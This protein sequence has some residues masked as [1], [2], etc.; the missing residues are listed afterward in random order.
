MI[1]SMSKVYVAAAAADRDKLLDALGKL[2][3]LHVRAVDPARAVAEEETVANIDHIGRAL[4]VLADV[5]PAGK[6]GELSAEQVAE[7]VL[8]IQRTSAELRSRLS[9]LHLQHEH[10][11]V[12]GDTRLG[13]LQQLSAAG[14]NVRFVSVRADQL[15]EL[16]GEC[17]QVVAEL[18]GKC[19]LAAVVDHGEQ[20]ADLPEGATELEMP[21]IDR[22]AIRAEAAEIDAQLKG[23]SRRLGE[24]ATLADTLA[25][26]RRQL[27]AQ[28]DYTVA[29][30][31]A[32]A[33]DDLYALQGWAPADEAT[34]LAGKLEE[35]G[36]HAAVD[37]LEPAE[38][39]QPPT[40]L[41]LPRWAGPIR[42]LF[43]IL[44][45]FPG[46][47]ELDVSSFFMFALPLFAAMLIGDGG[48]GIVLTVVPLI[49]YRSLTKRAGKAK[50]QLLIVFGLATV[51]WGAL[52][53]NY[54]GLTP[55]TFARTGGFVT[56]E[57]APDFPAMMAGGGGWA[58][59]GKGMIAAAP[60]WNADPNIV[61]QM[62]IKLSLLIGAIHL[63]LAH[64]R[65][66][67]FLAPSQQSLAEVGW[68]VFL[69]GMLGVIW[70]LFFGKDEPLPVPLRAV[71]GCLI[72]GAALAVLF[73][74]PARNPLKRIALG[75]ANA[76][77]PALGTFSD[78]MS[79]IRLMAVG[80]ASF[81][82]AYAFNVL[83]ASVASQATWIVGGVVAL[84]GH[85]LNIGM[86]MIAIFAH[87]VRLNMLEFS[88]NAGVQWAGYPYTPFT[89]KAGKEN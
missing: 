19:V 73:G 10:L 71:Y 53:A 69:A 50:V 15:A 32:L 34:D 1:V 23:L 74:S 20:T 51:A 55:E 86:A 54:F 66:A 82:I 72:G 63:A 26:R 4:Q 48:Y 16:T 37:L 70:L 8:G 57:G 21:K 44:D 80:L 13:Q 49:F 39:D 38:D 85:S 78:T 24:L 61:R 64:L 25:D 41:R 12:W 81:Y 35:M 47:R 28:A 36:L 9:A 33:D 84:A 3:V 6:P 27:Q 45:T 62:L 88:S 58:A 17:V 18:P 76:L 56:S 2:G 7:E 67:V 52:T 40:L 83:S 79:Y 43:E 22:P 87:G 31:S 68:S 65:R 14:L 60:L 77:L 75:L 11:A 5:T 30:R 46:Y 42:G 29:S 89:T 59:I